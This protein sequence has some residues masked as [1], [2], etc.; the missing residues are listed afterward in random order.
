MRAPAWLLA[1]GLLTISARAE[2][3]FSGVL[4]MP[5]RS[6]FALTGDT[7]GP[8]AWCALGQ[9]FAG[10]SLASF[11]AKT[12][13]LTL[14]KD[15]ATLCLPLKDAAKVK[16]ARAEFS[17]TITF[18]QGEK[19]DISRVTLV[20]DQETVLPLKEGLVWRITPTLTA[21]GN[22][23]YRL[24][25]DRAVQEGTITRTQRVSAPN[26]IARAGNSFSIAVGDL[27]FTFAPVSPSP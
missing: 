26:I 17:G 14:T 4:I 10:Y 18:G 15:G 11:D 21:D 5:G 16:S 23:R 24:V 12:D 20:Y 8:P 13:T 6:L 2:I 19:L 1:I 25:V 9:D 22:V 7:A 27:A 3:E